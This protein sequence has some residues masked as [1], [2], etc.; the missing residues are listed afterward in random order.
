ML[1]RVLPHEEP[2]CTAHVST[3][4]RRTWAIV[5]SICMYNMGRM[6][7]VLE[8]WNIHR[9]RRWWDMP[10]DTNMDPVMPIY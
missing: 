1:F 2:G 5:L 3:L 10:S 8:S 6:K 7:I 4:V 9:V